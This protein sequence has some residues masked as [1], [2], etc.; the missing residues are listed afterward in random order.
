MVYE[1]EATAV[2]IIKQ[3]V[4][5]FPV[6]EGRTFMVVDVGAGSVDITSHQV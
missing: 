4:R 5:P 2:A 6:A 3:H 1:S